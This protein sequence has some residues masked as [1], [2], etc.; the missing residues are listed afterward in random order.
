MTCFQAILDTVANGGVVRATRVHTRERMDKKPMS[1]S[2][3][4]A[5]VARALPVGSRTQRSVAVLHVT[6]IDYDSRKAARKGAI[7]KYGSFAVLFT[8]SSD[9]AIHTAT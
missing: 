5:L 6:D 7:S 1:V 8:R 3:M 2:A 4:K 9:H